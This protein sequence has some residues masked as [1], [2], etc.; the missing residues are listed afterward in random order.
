MD[1]TGIHGTNGTPHRFGFL[2]CGTNSLSILHMWHQLTPA[3]IEEDLDLHLVLPC[4]K[5][6]FHSDLLVK[7]RTMPHPIFWY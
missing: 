2:A 1:R 4:K 7:G 6:R 5:L 3:I